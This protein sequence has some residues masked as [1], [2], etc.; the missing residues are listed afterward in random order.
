MRVTAS[1]TLLG[2]ERYCRD[3]QFLQWNTKPSST[4]VVLLNLSHVLCMLLGKTRHKTPFPD[5]RQMFKVIDSR[6]A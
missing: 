3:Q 1:D 5:G 2:S 4:C 6:I